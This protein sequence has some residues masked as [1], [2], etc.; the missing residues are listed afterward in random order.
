[1]QP[2][3]VQE[4]L[5]SA[6]ETTYEA[7]IPAVTTVQ[8][9]DSF[10]SYPAQFSQPIN[11]DKISVEE[12]QL[13]EQE[14]PDKD[15]LS[16]DPEH[17][18][19]EENISD[20]FLT[21]LKADEPDDAYISDP[22]RMY[23]SKMDDY[24]LL[25]KQEEEE[26][27]ETFFCS[28]QELY[29]SLFS[30]FYVI[31][32]VLGMYEAIDEGKLQ[33]DRTIEWQG[34]MSDFTNEPPHFT[35]GE[36]P[37]ERFNVVYAELKRIYSSLERKYHELDNAINGSANS[38]RDSIRNLSN[39]AMYWILQAPPTPNFRNRY[40]N[41]IANPHKFVK[42][43]DPQNALE[44]L[45]ASQ[46]NIY[47][48]S[49]D[50][51]EAGNKLCNGNLRL[52]VSIAKRYRRKGL[53]FLDLIQDGNTG[54]ARAVEKFDYRTGNRFSTYATWWIRQ[55]IVRGISQKSRTIRVPN[56]INEAMWKYSGVVKSL[57][58]THQR[59]PSEEEIMEA[60]GLTKQNYQKMLS[61]RRNNIKIDRPIT[62]DSPNTIADF[63][64]DP[65]AVKPHASTEQAILRDRINSVLS[66]LSK[67]EQEVVALRFG[68]YGGDVKTLEQLGEEYG[69]TRERIRQI[70][71]SA[72]SKLRHPTRA[73]QLEPLLDALN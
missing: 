38:I 4:T 15:Y 2:A 19:D 58:A 10:I 28:K 14:D 34:Y 26:A 40:L 67:Q 47:R 37:K 35:N 50:L 24:P 11:E 20:D 39:D 7:R 13:L 44:D 32:E 62:P 52:V 65:C 16:L 64:E 25:T 53:S 29:R 36:T 45:V 17:E 69:V 5:E 23:F 63:L 54:L 12:D 3:Q 70:E 33:V 71:L 42:E 72:L 41:I 27:S 57:T 31:R 61:H 55:S 22:I 46:E 21:E 30:S 66:T 56:H 8:R 60:L 51:E 59:E 49:T 9:E 73:N 18:L 6:V 48:T 43:A 68:L 1:M